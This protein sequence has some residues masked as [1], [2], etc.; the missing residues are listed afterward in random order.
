VT[1][2]TKFGET[3]YSQ[4]LGSRAL[5][6]D[7]PLEKFLIH[8]EKRAFRMAYL[9]TSRHEDALDIVQDAMFKLVK[10]YRGRGEEELSMLFTRILQNQIRDWYRREKVRN[11]FSFL[12]GDR[13]KS[14]SE[15]KDN[16]EDPLAQ[17]PDTGMREPSEKMANERA[18]TTL[19]QAVKAL[20]LRQKQAFLLRAWEGLN[21]AQTATAMGCTQ[22]SVKTHYSR[23][24]HSLRDTLG[25]HRSW[26]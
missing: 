25:E 8:V 10:R 26:A 13:H 1:D 5:D 16:H 15:D 20:P 19:D 23:A 4:S 18:M 6:T 22:G 21:V 9:A 7:L 14:R 12:F 17:F 11:S 24:I 2:T 3:R